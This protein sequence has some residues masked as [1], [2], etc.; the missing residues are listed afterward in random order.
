MLEVNVYLQHKPKN[1]GM[2]KLFTVLKNCLSQ[3]KP[4]NKAQGTYYFSND[5]YFGTIKI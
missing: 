1:F 3:A 5:R 2:I 4:I